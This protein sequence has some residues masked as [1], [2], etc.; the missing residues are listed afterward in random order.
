M[1][2]HRLKQ[3]RSWSR[4]FIR[5]RPLVLAAFSYRYDHHLV[6]DLLQNL[7]PIVDGW[8]AFDDRSS[9]AV[10]SDELARRFRLIARARELGAGW[11]LAVDPDERFEARLAARIGTMTQRLDRIVWC[12][13]VRE[14]YTPTQYR[15]D[16]IW[17]RKVLGRLF[18]LLDGQTFADRPLHAPWYPIDPGY[19]FRRADLNLY[20]LKMIA[21]NR[22]RARRDLYRLL[23][24]QGDAQ[25]MGYDYLA[26]DRGA[27]LETIAPERGYL[28]PH[29]D[30]GGLWMA[31]P[32]PPVNAPNA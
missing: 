31:V 30:D 19:D 18:P 16:G 23:D 25:A 7:D 28:P 15:V 26:D 13:N 22:R 1:I 9:T 2:S 20:H 10:F 4:R 12:F 14:M 11:L 29:A 8:V 32:T 3:P 27:V 6:P 17:G 5:R 21:P 24:P